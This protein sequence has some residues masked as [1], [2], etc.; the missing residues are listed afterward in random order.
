M[1]FLVDLDLKAAFHQFLLDTRSS[2]L[3]TFTRL[4][5]EELSLFKLHEQG[6]HTSDLFKESGWWDSC[7]SD[8]TSSE[9][10]KRKQ[11]KEIR[12]VVKEESEK[13]CVNKQH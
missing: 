9:V 7:T 8:L 5:R 10:E 1:T 12:I 2:E 13:E 6:S 11:K 4:K 3:S